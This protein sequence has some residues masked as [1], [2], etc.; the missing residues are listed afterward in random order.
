ARLD[1]LHWSPFHTR[2]VI[3]LG[4]AWILDGLE[5]TVASS[6]AGVLTQGNTLHLTTAQ[7]AAIGSVYL[8]GEVVGALLFGKLA[9]KLG[10]RSLFMVTLGVY[11]FGS[12][13]TAFTLGT[14]TGWLIYMYATR[15]LA[16]AGIGGEYAAI[17]S[18]IDEMMPSRYRG[19]VDIWI[20]G[21]YWAGSILG[22]FVAILLLNTLP[23]SVGWR[24]GFLVGPALAVMILLVR[25]NLP[26]S[27]RWLITHGRVKEAEETM[28]QIETV[29]TSG[30]QVLAAVDDSAAIGAQPEEDYG[31]LTVLRPG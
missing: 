7:A 8:I 1:R 3:G 2:M 4:V 25:R 10:R 17:N 18:A 26:E 21:T 11:L 12:G 6:I 29:A 9:D 28:R 27:P 5:I 23:V 19:R 13:L 14:G 15:L 24:I 22:S 31:D 16:G 30:G 20:N